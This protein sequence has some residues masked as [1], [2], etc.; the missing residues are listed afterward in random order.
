ME[1]KTF[2]LSVSCLSSAFL[3]FLNYF[4]LEFGHLGMIFISHSANASSEGIFL[5]MITRLKWLIKS[6]GGLYIWTL[7]NCQ[8]APA[9]F[10]N[11]IEFRHLTL[12]TSK[13]CP[14]L[15]TL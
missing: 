9:G 10:P 4:F 5:R 8:Y 12:S 6:P 1:L 3:Y 14:E 7:I 2:K 15:M 11:I 13:I